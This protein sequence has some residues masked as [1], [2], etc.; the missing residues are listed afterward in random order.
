MKVI[1]VL[2]FKLGECVH[3]VFMIVSNMILRQ[4]FDLAFEPNLQQSPQMT[5]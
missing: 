5:S 3:L 1:N 2:L 4:K